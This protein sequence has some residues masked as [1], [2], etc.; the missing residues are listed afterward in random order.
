M[1]GL[2]R[3]TVG[4]LDN[5]SRYDYGSMESLGRAADR[6][7]WAGDIRGVEAFALIGSAESLG[8]ATFGSMDSLGQVLGNRDY[9]R[10]RSDGFGSSVE[11]L[12][13][14]LDRQKSPR[15][16]KSRRLSDA[17]VDGRSDAENDVARKVEDAARKRAISISHREEAVPEIDPVVYGREPE[18]TPRNLER[19]EADRKPEIIASK[20]ADFGGSAYT[21]H[22]ITFAAA[23]R[24]FAIPDL[25][26]PAILPARPLISS[27]NLVRATETPQ[28]ME[29]ELLV[30]GG[31]GADPAPLVAA[32]EETST[33][34]K[35]ETPTVQA[36]AE[37]NN[38]PAAQA[39]LEA[40][41]SSEE[42]TLRLDS[43]GDDKVSCHWLI[44]TD[45]AQGSC[46]IVLLC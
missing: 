8:R 25:G 14:V 5:L 26:P 6:P 46:R 24:P 31:A 41:A 30:D 12:H 38:T 44:I 39:D 4:S 27:D 15:P 1:D 18:I 42:Q 45:K 9:P 43:A 16:A 19:I 34:T 2:S 28:E 11:S 3:M 37:D 17:E 40:T 35:Y 7:S 33:E 32:F 22:L 36:N 21:P 13:K 20:A 10:R 23:E 29:P